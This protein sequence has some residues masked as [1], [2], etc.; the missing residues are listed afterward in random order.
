MLLWM[1]TFFATGIG[2]MLGAGIMPKTHSDGFEYFT[3][4]ME[5]FAAGAMLTMIAQTMLPEAFHQG[6][7]VIGMSCLMGF[8]ATLMVKMVPLNSAELS[9]GNATTVGGGTGHH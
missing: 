1:S 3:K 4:G 9:G 5:G 7:N 8:L 2:S 6:G